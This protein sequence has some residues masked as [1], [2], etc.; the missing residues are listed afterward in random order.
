MQLALV[1]ILVGYVASCSLI[2]DS[3]KGTLVLSLDTRLVA[4]TIEPDLSMDVDHY[5]IYG[6]GPGSAYFEQL[7]VDSNTVVQA[8]LIPGEWTITVEAYN[9]D[10]PDPTQIGEGVAVVTITSGEV[11][12]TTVTVTPLDG[13]GYLELHVT[14]PEG[15]LTNPTLNATLTPADPATAQPSISFTGDFT[16][17]GGTGATDSYDLS[18]MPTTLETGYYTLVLTLFDG[19]GA[20]VWGTVEAVRIIKDETSAKT[21]ALV[22]DVNRGGLELEIIE[23][24]D[25]PFEI[26]FEVGGNE[27]TDVLVANGSDLTVTAIATDATVDPG[28]WT[29]YLQGQPHSAT[30]NTITLTDAE[31]GLGYYWLDV[32]AQVGDVLSSATLTF[33]V[34]DAITVSASNDDTAAAPV[35]AQGSYIVSFPAQTNNYVGAEL[36]ASETLTLTLYDAVG[37]TFA[38]YNAGGLTAPGT[39]SF[40]SGADFEELTY[41]P[42]GDETVYI[43]INL[44]SVPTN[45]Y[46]MDIGY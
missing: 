36:L 13:T 10:V 5:D 42:A 30:A 3:S 37:A 26:T 40:T 12:N 21:F 25:N 38:A 8:S 24:L 22:E 28:D 6:N 41:E 7:D 31:L 18:P 33:Q 20:L 23:E 44:P 16:V 35:L 27:V 2:G 45:P 4:Q 15:V 32:V 43:A 29:W 1:V 14:W 46:L 34:V 39:L 17:Q 19:D 9:G 11:L